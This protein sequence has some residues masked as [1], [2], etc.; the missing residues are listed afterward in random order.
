MDDNNFPANSRVGRAKND[1][2]KSRPRPERVTT[3]KVERRKTPLGKRLKALFVG[4]DASSVGRYILFEVLLPAAKDAISEATSQGVDRMIFGENRRPGGSRTHSRPSGNS[5]YTP[6]NRYASSPPWKADRREEPR[7]E[8]SRRSRA[9][10]DFGEIFLESRV[11][12][13]E[14]I[15]KLFD[16]VSQYGQATVSDLYDLVGMTPQFTDE[17][18]GWNDLEGADTKRTRDGYILLLPPPEI[19]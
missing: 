3:G 2:E 4:G 6:Y 12:A 13:E 8:T 19:L 7:R 10:H 14:V 9:S 5:S 16:L 11:E 17:K 1:E 18:W 15:G